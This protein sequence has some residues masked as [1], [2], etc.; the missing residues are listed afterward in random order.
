MGE[1]YHIMYGGG[2]VSNHQLFYGDLVLQNHHDF[3]RLQTTMFSSHRLQITMN[4]VAAASNH[5]VHLDRPAPNHHIPSSPAPDHHVSRAFR[6]APLVKR[7]QT[8][9]HREMTGVAHSWTGFKSPCTLTQAI[10]MSGYF[11]PVNKVVV[12]FCF[13]LGN[14]PLCLWII[15]EDLTSKKR[16]L[17][18]DEVDASV[19]PNLCTEP[20]HKTIFM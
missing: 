13:V 15:F 3:D 19:G 10:V 6:A 1:S 16:H 11:R 7:L 14:V 9:M 12:L 2:E 20:M 8:T 5:H 17:A 4:P 18:P